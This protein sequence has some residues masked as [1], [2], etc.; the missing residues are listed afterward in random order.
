[1]ADTPLRPDRWYHAKIQENPWGIPLGTSFPV[2]KWGK[3]AMAVVIDDRT[4]IFLGVAFA[5]LFALQKRGAAWE[6]APKTTA[7]SVLMTHLALRQIDPRPRV[8]ATRFI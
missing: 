8:D 4:R 3:A 5:K 6:E 2:R 1:M 7:D